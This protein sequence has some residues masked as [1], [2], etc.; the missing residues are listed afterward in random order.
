MGKQATRLSKVNEG[1]ATAAA[2][3]DADFSL[4]RYLFNVI[5]QLEQAY[6]RQVQLAL[7]P[8]KVSLPAWRVLG[9]LREHSGCTTT[10][11]AERTVIERTALTRVVQQMEKAGL[12]RRE[13]KAE[14]R[15]AQG[16]Y[17]TDTGQDLLFRILP[18]ID[19]VY[20][21]VTLGTSA[22]ELDDLLAAL[23]NL[24]RRAR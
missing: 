8:H 19:R 14:D 20:R 21:R 23:T 6:R 7:R 1:G 22:A 3:L 18:S 17:L 11:L 15:R 2:P 16:V 24:R 10:E 12:I 5:S 9:V 13:V 4:D